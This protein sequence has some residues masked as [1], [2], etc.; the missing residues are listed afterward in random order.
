MVGAVNLLGFAFANADL[1]LEIDRAGTVV[2]AT[3]AVSEFAPDKDV[4]LIGRGAARLFEPS[5]GAKFMTYARALDKGG[6]AG[7]LRMK[8]ANGQEAAVSLCNLPQNGGHISCTLA[9]PGQRQGFGTVSTDPQTRLATKDAFLAAASGMADGDN[10]MTLVDVPA[11]PEA[12]AALPEADANRLMQR[13]GEVVQ[14][15]G[16]KASGR[17]SDTT[18]GAV[19]EAGRQSKLASDIKAALKEGGLEHSKVAETLVALTGG[20]LTAEQRLLAVRHVVGRFAQGKHD[21]KPGDDLA[22]V[23]DAMVGETQARALAL[24]DTV[25]QGGF[26][27]VYQS[28]HDLASGALSHCEALARFESADTTSETV[29]FAEALGISD[30]FD[31]AVAAKVLSEAEANTEA[32]ISLNLSG[33]TLASPQTFALVAGLLACKRALA[34]RVQIELTETAE[35][36]DLSSANQ[37]IQAVRSMGFKVGLDDFG[38]GAAS[39]HYLHTFEVDFVKFD[40]TLIGKLGASPRDDMLL[41]GIVKL[42]K[43]LDMTTVAEGIETAELLKRTRAIGFD[44]GQGHHLGKPAHEPL[45]PPKPAA[46]SAHRKGEQVTWG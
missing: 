20:E 38:A 31:V 2:F 34:K 9:H 43:E 21:G 12:C 15:A 16:S 8:L 32:K 42:C 22:A 5:D 36:A 27:L 4:E 37:A 6:R 25:L 45:A 17:V 1:L 30:A 18:F 23:F 40:G 35:I 10:A 33:N 44:L 29:A 46:Q 28:V 19:T 14:A 39:F 7:P 11:L 41:S 24:T 13:I 3:G 26:T